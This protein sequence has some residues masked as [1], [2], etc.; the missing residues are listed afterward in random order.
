[1][2][3]CAAGTPRQRLAA[4]AQSSWPEAVHV[5]QRLRDDGQKLD[6][7]HFSSVATSC[8]RAGAW[9]VVLGLLQA[10]QL[11]AILPD[12]IYCSNSGSDGLRV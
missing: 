2:V 12:T 8:A 9:K 6:V 4:V 5:L 10:M 11:S 1:M 7:F 3:A